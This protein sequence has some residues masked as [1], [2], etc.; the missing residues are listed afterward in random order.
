M[1]LGVT[2]KSICNQYDIGEPLIFVVLEKLEC[3]RTIVLKLQYCKMAT[4]TKEDLIPLM[5][6]PWEPITTTKKTKIRNVVYHLPKDFVDERYHHLGHHGHGVEGESVVVP[7]D[8]LDADDKHR[9]D[10][11][12][13]K[14]DRFDQISFFNLRHQKI[15]VK[16]INIFLEQKTIG[17]LLSAAAYARDRISPYLFNYAF[18]STVLHREDTACLDLPSFVS[19]F[20]EKFIQS[21]VLKMALHEATYVKSKDRQSIVIPWDYSATNKDP[22]HRLAYFR[23]DLGVN[24]HHWHWHLVYPYYGPFSKKDRRGELFYYMHRQMVARYNA[25]RFCNKL[26]RVERLIDFRSRMREAYYSKINNDE[27]PGRPAFQK[28]RNL[29]RPHTK[30]D[31]VDLEI[32]RSRI[33]GAISSGHA[34]QPDGK[35][36]PLSIDALG[37]MIEASPEKSPNFAYYGN[38][39]NEGHDIISLVHDPDNRHLENAG[40]M[41]GTSTAVRDPIFFR[42]HAFIDYFF[43][44]YQSTLPSYTSDELSFSDLSITDFKVESD[45]ETRKNTFVTSWLQSDVDVS[46]GLDFLGDGTV[47]VGFTHLTHADFKYHINYENNGPERTGTCRIFLSPKQNEAN[48]KWLFNDQRL[49]LIEL[50]RFPVRLLPGTNNIIRNSKNSSVTIPLDRIF[51]SVNE[52]TSKDCST[53]FCRC[54]WPDYML[55]P[56]GTPEGFPCQLFVMISNDN[57]TGDPKIPCFEDAMSYCGSKDGSK[58]PDSRPMGFPFDREL[59]DSNA[60]LHEFINPTKKLTYTNMRL[61]DVKIR[62]HETKGDEHN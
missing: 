5:L 9:I 23:E 45:G 8:D 14:L 2:Y 39:H 17:N 50:D 16:L 21:T 34:K 57:L 41:S 19:I 54:G 22:E 48:E 61:I 38:L 62:L 28:L 25:E 13:K 49:F 24:S 60:T 7:V 56:R 26:P 36:I 15:A 58:F 3:Y 11:I 37:D 40:V 53:P 18:T 6:R 10:K 20:P 31:V 43:Q 44:R 1:P 32:W 55:I 4:I 47:H 42:W 59:E 12:A 30:L 52:D 35:L 33:L 27:Y 29:D 51:N 46:G